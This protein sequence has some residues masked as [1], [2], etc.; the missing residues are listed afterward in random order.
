MR[1]GGSGVAPLAETSGG[2]STHLQL[3]AL[4]RGRHVDAHGGHACR[5]DIKVNAAPGAIA[6]G[7]GLV[8]VRREGVGGA[9][10]LVKRRAD[11]CVSQRDQVRLGT[12]TTG[13]RVHTSL[14]GPDRREGGEHA[15][16]GAHIERLNCRQKVGTNG[17]SNCSLEQTERGK[18]LDTR[19]CASW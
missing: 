12:H 11:D 8:G 10:V 16:N 1:G 2:G 19:G 15:K 13:A 18:G 6:G 17:N 9:A 3:G 7:S 14:G 5:R 4:V